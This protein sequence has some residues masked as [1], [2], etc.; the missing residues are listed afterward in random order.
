MGWLLQLLT[1]LYQAVASYT[2][3]IS[4]GVTGEWV[5]PFFVWLWNGFKILANIFWTFFFYGVL[6]GLY[7]RLY[8]ESERDDSDDYAPPRGPDVWRRNEAETAEV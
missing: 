7:G 5:Q 2:R 1:A 6:A 4:S 8:R 3:L